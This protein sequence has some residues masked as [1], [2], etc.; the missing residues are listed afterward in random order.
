MK[1]LENTGEINIQ[2]TNKYRIITVCNYESYQDNQQA[3]NNQTNKQLTSNQQAT[4][5][6]LTT[7][8][9]EKNKKNDNNE[10]NIYIPEFLE[11]KNYVLENE[12]NIDTIHP[13]VE[14]DTNGW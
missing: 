7:N 8:K 5:K 13:N 11:F 4:N 9:N 12:P 3:S 2:T 6:Q 10:K 14:I 1:R